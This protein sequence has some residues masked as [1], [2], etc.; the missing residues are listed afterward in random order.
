[1]G[2][3]TSD[4]ELRCVGTMENKW[5]KAMGANQP[6]KAPVI[7]PT[8]PRYFLRRRHSNGGMLDFRH[9]LFSDRHLDLTFGSVLASCSRHVSPGPPV[10]RL[11]VSLGSWPRAQENN[12]SGIAIW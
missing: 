8:W 1:M 9:V 12:L 10:V 2:E 5:G 4:V 11:D 6:Q 7:T 3:M